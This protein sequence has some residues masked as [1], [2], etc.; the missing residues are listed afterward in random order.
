MKCSELMVGD[1]AQDEKGRPMKIKAVEE[2]SIYALL[3]DERS[4]FVKDIDYM[5][6]FDDNDELP[7]GIPLTEEIL[8]KNGFIPDTGRQN[9]RN[10]DIDYSNGITSMIYVAMKDKRIETFVSFTENQDKIAN[11][12]TL[13]HCGMYVHE[14]Q[15][16]L[17]LAGKK[18]SAD[19]FQI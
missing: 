11:T 9:F 19:N 16:A 5:N 12:I 1:W 10:I 18:E 13:R 15:H 4:I 7:Y 17:R 8:Q 14:L 3:S 2:D 6:E